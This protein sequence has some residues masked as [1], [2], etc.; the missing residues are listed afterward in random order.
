MCGRFTQTKSR[1]E[2]L[3]ALNNIEL[4]PLFHGRYNVAPTQEVAVIKASNLNQA[5]FLR[6]GFQVNGIDRLIINA[7]QETLN[8]RPLF[9]PL[10]AHNRC[11]IPADGFYEW[12]GKTPYYFHLPDR[13]LFGLAGLWKE[14]RCVVIT[15]TAN[16][17]M[18]SIHDRMPLILPIDSWDEWL[19]NGSA[20]PPPRLDSFA[21]SQ[22]VNRVA[23]DDPLCLKPADVQ[24]DL[25]L[26]PDEE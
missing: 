25:S 21:V 15:R 23:N 8:E 2:V 4:P 20:P 10:L 24:T 5:E 22:R 3:E 6:W 11:L 7:R 14:D 12:K 9:K 19:N 13:R 17:S 1:K 18:Q 26:F 16:A